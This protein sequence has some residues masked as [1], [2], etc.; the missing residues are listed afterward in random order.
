MCPDS[1]EK[2]QKYGQDKPVF[3]APLAPFSKT[4]QVTN[5]QSILSEELGQVHYGLQKLGTQF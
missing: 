3:S 2:G 1:R 4:V 5:F